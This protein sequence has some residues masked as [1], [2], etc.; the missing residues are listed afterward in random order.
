[1]KMIL[2]KLLSLF[3]MLSAICILGIFIRPEMRPELIL[4]LV[5]MIVNIAIALLILKR[6]SKN[7]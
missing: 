6:I 1:M 3:V 5:V 2:E 7:H 4:S